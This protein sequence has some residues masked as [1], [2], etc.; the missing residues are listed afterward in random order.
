M[1][2]TELDRC[3][4]LDLCKRVKRARAEEVPAEKIMGRFGLSQH[5]LSIVDTV[6]A[7]A[8]QQVLPLTWEREQPGNGAA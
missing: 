7:Y 8:A 1:S 6:N 5:G 2:I 3:Q 4:F